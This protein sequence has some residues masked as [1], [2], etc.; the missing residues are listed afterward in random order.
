MSNNYEIWIAQGKLTPDWSGPFSAVA[1]A[2][3][4]GW[5]RSITTQKDD[6]LY[7]TFVLRDGIKIYGGFRGT[8][9]TADDRERRDYKKYETILSG[10][11]GESGKVYRPV[12]A[13]GIAGAVLDGLSVHGGYNSI[14][15]N[16]SYTINGKT[17]GNRYSGIMYI[18][19]ANPLL[20]NVTFDNGQS[21]ESS[22]V[23]ITGVSHPALINCSV[24]SCQSSGSGSAIAVSGASAH[25][26]M[27]GGTL[28]LNWD[29]GGV[30]SVS[31]GKITLVNTV[32]RNNMDNPINLTGSGTGEFI[33]L[34]IT[35]NRGYATYESPYTINGQAKLYNCVVRDNSQ[36]R[37][38]GHADYDALGTGQGFAATIA[39]VENT[40][41][42]GL[43]GS[44][45][46]ETPL[47]DRGDPA[48][49]P[50]DQNGNLTAFGTS[51]LP[52][53]LTPELLAEVK[54]ALLA[55]ANGKPRFKG[56][57][58]D[59]GAVEQQ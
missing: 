39:L 51:V 8:E 1:S 47:L 31:S 48:Y 50:V 6:P 45:P 55:D 13:A 46:A 5:A 12:V 16:G 53:A 15:F 11:L 17:L 4:T 57:E 19:D 35:G 22:G 18:F 56:T 54:K 28:T 43:T 25:P 7:W 3:G 58:I 33:N 36:F 37:S 21:S 27:I 38:A 10:D 23:Y 52:A 49:Y 40:L 9:V 32:I 59:L 14:G 26:V 2:S 34:S 30:L 44:L 42:P 24:S 41:A 20:K 29:A